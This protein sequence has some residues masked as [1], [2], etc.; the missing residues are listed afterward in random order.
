MGAV[1]KLATV[2]MIGLV[3]LATVFLVYAA[4]EPDRR[5]EQV[6]RQDD[7]AIERGTELFITYCLQCHAPDGT[8]AM[9]KTG[10]I[11]GI[12]NQSGIE[13]KSGLPI[14]YQTDDPAMQQK[15]DHFIRYRLENGYP[16]DPREE[17]KMPAFGQDLNVEQINDLVYLIMHVDW[18]YVYNEAMIETGKSEQ[19][20]TCTKD[21]SD[22]ICSEKEPLAYPTVPPT[23]VP[24]AEAS[25]AAGV[26][27]V[28]AGS[29][30]GAASS[31]A[32]VLELDAQDVSWSQKDITL[33]PGDTITV[34]NTG[35]LL[36]DFVVD[37]LGIKV[38]VESGESATVTI[39]ADAKPGTY[40]FYC[41]QPGH[42]ESG[43]V[44]TLTIGS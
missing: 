2:V 29:D 18:N 1:Q 15:A 38:E 6:N 4:N 12:L 40:T 10:R 19:T 33:K 32:P 21:P 9:E 14:V 11:G 35:V 41:S 44:G 13:D 26:T 22:A 27:P 5:D 34:K 20:A 7:L 37:E 39:P 24:A 42:K 30:S 36:H 8:G 23:A 16:G 3:A 31:G 28:A 43:M 25:P 17:L